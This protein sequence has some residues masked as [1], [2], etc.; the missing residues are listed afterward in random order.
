MGLDKAG[1]S[2][3]RGKC[4]ARQKGRCNFPARLQTGPTTGDPIDQRPLSVSAAMG[5]SLGPLVHGGI[6]DTRS[7]KVRGRRFVVPCEFRLLATSSTAPRGITADVDAFMGIPYA[8]PP[9]GELRF[10][11]DSFL[12]GFYR[13]LSLSSRG[14]TPG[15]AS[16][17]ALAVHRTTASFRASQRPRQRMKT[18]SLSTSSHRLGRMPSLWVS[19]F[20]QIPAQR[21]PGDGLHPRRQFRDP[22]KLVLW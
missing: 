10:K 22:G 12:F 13:S 9:I 4:E 5:N 2:K 19:L 16:T 6:V 3:S 7:G 1:S 11:V 21:T 18:V 14:R 20:L 17:L 8:K 15:T